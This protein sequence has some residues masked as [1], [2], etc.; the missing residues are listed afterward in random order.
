MEDDYEDYDSGPF[1]QHYDH[2]DY[3]NVMC[4][5]GHPCRDHYCDDSCNACDC[6][7]FKDEEE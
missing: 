3:C 4:T 2:P 6:D 1:C 5:C 7:K